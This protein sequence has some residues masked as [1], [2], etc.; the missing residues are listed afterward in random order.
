MFFLLACLLACR[1][2][3]LLFMSTWEQIKGSLSLAVWHSSLP[4]MERGTVQ[5]GQSPN[6]WA[7]LGALKWQ[8]AEFKEKGSSEILRAFQQPLVSGLNTS[9]WTAH[10]PKGETLWLL[11]Q[12]NAHATM[13]RKPKEVSAWQWRLGFQQ[14]GS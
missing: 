13:I 1:Y 11:G 14:A 5:A 12:Q 4:S 8:R 7:N 10:W 3:I 9:G 2:L 6:V